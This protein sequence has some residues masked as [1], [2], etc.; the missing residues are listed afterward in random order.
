MFRPPRL[1]DTEFAMRIS[2]A[3]ND[4]SDPTTRTTWSTEDLG[5]DS[6][7]RT[8]TAISGNDGSSTF[9]ADNSTASA[10]TKSKAIVD[11][12]DG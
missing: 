7:R 5:S 4:G 12:T 6:T 8:R 1:K 3:A 2:R 11:V 10:R 9:L